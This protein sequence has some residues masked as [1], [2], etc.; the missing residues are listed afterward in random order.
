MSNEFIRN[1]CQL[2][3]LK[4]DV[5]VFKAILSIQRIFN[6]TKYWEVVAKIH[7]L[8]RSADLNLILVPATTNRFIFQII[9]WS[10][11]YMGVLLSWCGCKLWLV[12]FIFLL[13]M[14][15][16]FTYSNIYVI[17]FEWMTGKNI[18]CA[19]QYNVWS[20]LPFL[21]LSII[22][23]TITTVLNLEIQTKH[24]IMDLS[25]YKGYIYQTCSSRQCA[26]AH[27]FML[28]YPHSFPPL[29][30]HLPRTYLNLGHLRVG[31]PGENS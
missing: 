18:N 21:F 8:C 30:S 16:A 28:V 22:I 24:N 5:N 7:Y 13:A 15:E 23:T 19:F 9:N 17:L 14:I 2:K 25:V 12:I 27:S 4:F 6:L 1:F 29:G 26:M 10:M 20:Q 3:L 31:A 11:K